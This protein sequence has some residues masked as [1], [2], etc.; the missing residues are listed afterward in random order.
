MRETRVWVDE[1]AR[2]AMNKEMVFMAG[3]INQ[4]ELLK[5]FGGLP[6]IKRPEEPILIAWYKKPRYNGHPLSPRGQR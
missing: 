6:E 3:L 4:R 5:K 1:A 2:L